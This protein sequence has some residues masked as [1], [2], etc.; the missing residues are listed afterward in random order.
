MFL[1][2]GDGR[3]ILATL[4]GTMS[5][6]AIAIAIAEVVAGLLAGCGSSSTVRLS[7]RIVSGFGAQLRRQD[8][9]LRCNPTGGDTPN[10]ITLCRMIAA[11]PQA[12]LQ[13]G[14][15]RSFCLGGQGIP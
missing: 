13:P 14:R 12:M 15:P 3:R 10:R 6:R 4:L 7:V 2:A 5:N 9:T 11:H 8:F 1:K